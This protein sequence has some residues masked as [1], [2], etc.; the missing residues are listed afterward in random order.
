MT[1]EQF[2]QLRTLILDQAVKIEGLAMEVRALK[3]AVETTEVVYLGP[4]D[5]GDPTD[6]P[7]DIRK[8]LDR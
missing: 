1:E 5:F 4:E 2:R 8:L 7:E 3:R 6:I